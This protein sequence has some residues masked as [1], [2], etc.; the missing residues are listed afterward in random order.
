MK[1][2][3]LNLLVLSGPLP[4]CH[5]AALPFIAFTLFVL[6]RSALRLVFGIISMRMFSYRDAERFDNV[7]VV[8][9][10]YYPPRTLTHTV[11]PRD[12]T[13]LPDN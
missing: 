3:N 4:A 13:H 8:H 2:G 11:H 6:F 10:C 5:G 12:R 1:S 9:D 7:I